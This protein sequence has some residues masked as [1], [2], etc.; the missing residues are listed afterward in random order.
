MLS[1]FLSTSR[2][3]HYSQTRHSRTQPCKDMC[4]LIWDRT[5][6]FKD[7]TL[8]GK[9]CMN[10]LSRRGSNFLSTS[11]IHHY[12][13]TR[14]SRTHPYKD[15]CL[16]IWD[17][18]HLFKDQTLEGK[19]CM[20]FPSRSVSNWRCKVCTNRL[21]Q[22]PNFGISHR[23]SLQVVDHLDMW[24]ICQG[25]GMS[26]KMSGT[27]HKPESIHQSSDRLHI[28][29]CLCLIAQCCLHMISTYSALD[30]KKGSLGHT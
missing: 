2:I 3:H 18:T 14:H 8:E 19:F 25:Q 6:L 23:W 9:F 21:R 17:R 22:T 16:L 24:H 30:Y 28:H 20:N 11:R 4:L 13:Q 27:W 5:H 26:G 29:K 1:N 12:S 7:Q 15:M 10:F